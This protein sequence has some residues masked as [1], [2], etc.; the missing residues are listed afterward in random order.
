MFDRSKTK[1]QN[2]LSSTQSKSAFLNG[3]PIRYRQRSVT[4]FD[5]LSHN[6]I[7]S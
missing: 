2:P 3:T 7:A 5:L 4:D 6:F 1:T